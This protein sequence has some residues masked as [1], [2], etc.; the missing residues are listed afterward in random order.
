MRGKP[1][2][3]HIPQRVLLVPTQRPSD[4]MQLVFAQDA[5]QTEHFAHT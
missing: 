1:T 2:K 5:P 3:R 4:H